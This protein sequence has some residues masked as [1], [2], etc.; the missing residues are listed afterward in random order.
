MPNREDLIAELM[1]TLWTFLGIGLIILF[2]TWVLLKLRS[3]F[4]EDAD[5]STTSHEMLTRIRDLHRQGELSDTEYR[6]IKGRLVDGLDTSR[7]GARPE[8][9]T[10]GKDSIGTEDGEDDRVADTSTESTTEKP[11]A[12]DEA[13]R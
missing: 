9:R 1:G 2:G 6:S 7:S 10:D 3:R 8:P 13:R 5:S 11:K 12:E 4:E